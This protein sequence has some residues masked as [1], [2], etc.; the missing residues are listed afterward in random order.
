MI[1]SEDAPFT[2][3]FSDCYKILP[4]EIDIGFFQSHLGGKS[5]DD[6]IYSSNNK[7]IM[8][9]SELK[10]WIKKQKFS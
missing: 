7:K 10:K 6:F 9:I 2:Y 4:P 3:E 1:G 8:K 5:K